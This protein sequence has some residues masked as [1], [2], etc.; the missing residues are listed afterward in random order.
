[1]RA[2]GKILALS[3]L[4]LIFCVISTPSAFA[5]IPEGS[6]LRTTEPI[7]IG[8][9]ILPPG[10]YVIRVLPAIENRNLLQV[11]NEDGSKIFAT[12]LSIPHAYPEMVSPQST[13]YV[14]YPT[15]TGPRALRTWFAPDSAS[16]GGHDI[17]YPQQRAIE[18]ASTVKEPVVAYA[19]ETPPEDLKTSPLVIVTPDR[20]I[21]PYVAPVPAPK[22]AKVEKIAVKHPMPR[23]ASNVP[24]FAALGLMLLGAAI[25]IRVMRIA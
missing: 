2:A 14:F 3:A 22:M 25:A 12:V 23:T 20:K 6:Y 11:T 5:T 24:L 4:A 13:E 8:G 9:T 15:T 19:A 18:L 7:D 21:A 17:V 10:V 16:G 1:M